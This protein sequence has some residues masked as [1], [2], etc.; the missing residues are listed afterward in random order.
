M[1]L[2][3]A[4]WNNE[5]IPEVV[6]VDIHMLKDDCGSKSLE[7]KDDIETNTM[8]KMASHLEDNVLIVDSKELLLKT[9]KSSKISIKQAKTMKWINSC[10]NTSYESFEDLKDGKAIRDLLDLSTFGVGNSFQHECHVW[11]D[12]D[13]LLCNDQELVDDIDLELLK[14]VRQSEVCKLMGKIRTNV[15]KALKEAKYK[16]QENSHDQ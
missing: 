8:I 13:I 10:L 16:E 12:I 5:I 15:E 6:K 9:E 4:F 11:S 2:G 7:D 3:Y 1:V 14:N